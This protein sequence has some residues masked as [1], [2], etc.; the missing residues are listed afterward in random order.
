VVRLEVSLIEH[1]DT[2]NWN[3]SSHGFNVLV[4]HFEVEQF[5]EIFN[6]LLET[7][8]MVQ[9]LVAEDGGIIRLNGCCLDLVVSCVRAHQG[10]NPVD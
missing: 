5:T 2:E 1:T 9:M 10:L 3:F 8:F 7:K 6:Q 4:E